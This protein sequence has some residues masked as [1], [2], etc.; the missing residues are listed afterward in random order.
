[1]VPSG[2]ADR[3]S[4]H[5]HSLVVDAIERADVVMMIGVIEYHADIGQVLGRWPRRPATG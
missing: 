4:C 3:T 2:L 1:V 5:V